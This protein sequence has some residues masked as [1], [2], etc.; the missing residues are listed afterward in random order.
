MPTA[1]CATIRAHAWSA[2]EALDGDGWADDVRR[3]G[4]GRTGG[5]ALAATGVGD[6]AGSS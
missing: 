3:D 4:E 2:P 5:G 1:F 6:G